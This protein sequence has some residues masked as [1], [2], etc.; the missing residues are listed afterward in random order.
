M[1][2]K[3]HHWSSSYT[4]YTPSMETPDTHSS[5]LVWN[6]DFRFRSVLEG[7]EMQMI[8][9]ALALVLFCGLSLN[10]CVVAALVRESMY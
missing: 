4:T 8:E 2:V 1:Q 6:R 7:R 9:L 5:Q 3:V 10:V